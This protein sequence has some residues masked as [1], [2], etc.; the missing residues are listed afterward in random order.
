MG[1][2]MTTTAHAI[3]MAYHQKMASVILTG[4][5]Q[6]LNKHLIKL[7]AFDFS[8][9]MRRHFKRELRNWLIEI[10]AIRLKPTTRTGSTRFY[11]EHLFDYPFG[12]VEVQNTRALIEL[13][14]SEYDGM[15]AKRTPE[16]MAAWL[17]AFHGELAERLHEGKPVLDLIPE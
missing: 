2:E 16:D 10:Q 4:M 8:P 12:G 14:A 3:E 15:E 1:G 13:I 5:A 9:D 6:P 11:F 17:K 7:V